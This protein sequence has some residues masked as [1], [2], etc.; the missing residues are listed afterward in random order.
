ML[1]CKQLTQAWY[2]LP[3]SVVEYPLSKQ[4]ISD[5]PVFEDAGSD[6][7]FVESSRHTEAHGEFGVT[8]KARARFNKIRNGRNDT[9]DLRHRMAML[10]SSPLN[11]Y[12]LCRALK[13]HLNFLNQKLGA[14]LGIPHLGEST[15]SSAEQVFGLEEDYPVMFRCGCAL[16]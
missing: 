7:L 4:T 16:S 1:S 6:A 11:D 15:T 10:R 13:H 5:A 2:F 8:C 3:T 14:R 12:G 9:T